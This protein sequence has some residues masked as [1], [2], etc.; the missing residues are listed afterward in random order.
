MTVKVTK[1]A[2][3]LREKLAELDKPSGVA[4]EAM[5]RAETP[6]EQFNLIG[7]GRKNLI[8]NGAMKVAQRGTSATISDGVNEGYSTLD[9]W[10]TNYGS[11]QGGALTMEQTSVGKSNALKLTCTTAYPTLSSL[12]NFT[13][14]QRIETTNIASHLDG[15][16]SVTV[17]F[18]VRT[19]KAGKYG[20]SIFVSGSTNI[21][22]GGAFELTGTG[23]WEYVTITIPPN[24]VSA[25][26]INYYDF[27]I[28]LSAGTQ[29][30]DSSTANWIV[31]PG[32]GALMPEAIDNFFDS[33][34]NYIE[35][36]EFQLEL[37]KVATPFE[38]RSYG[39]E[40]ALCQRYY[41]KSYTEAQY[42]GSIS[43]G[44]AIYWRTT[45]SSSSHAYHIRLPSPMRVAPT[46]TT[47]N[48]VT[49]ASGN[50]RGS[51]GVDYTATPFSIGTSAFSVDLGTNTAGQYIQAAHWVADAEL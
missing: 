15:D 51:G 26:T 6:Q 39:E 2:V 19:N 14:G 40:L 9:R 3:N 41:Q 30:I 42:A 48:G 38:H 21:V 27:R 33:T 25:S 45:S 35:F 36:T 34:S 23:S 28:T 18:K 4:G 37:G 10:L 29:R 47:Y 11:S 49:G 13:I 7:A 16:D 12:H 43:T 8:I 31:Y 46:C 17:S 32:S 24:T 50:W 20:Y 1:P 5:L 22:R 44:G